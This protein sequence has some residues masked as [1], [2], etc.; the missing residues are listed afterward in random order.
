MLAATPASIRKTLEDLD[1]DA[2]IDTTKASTIFGKRAVV[3]SVL[4]GIDKKHPE[5]VKSLTILANP[6]AF[7]WKALHSKYVTAPPAPLVAQTA[8]PGAGPGPSVT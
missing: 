8:A 3:D 2:D 7:L 4:E 6:A 1:A 5:E